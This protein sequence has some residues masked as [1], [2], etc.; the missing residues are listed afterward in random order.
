MK[1]IN[2]IL[3]WLEIAETTDKRQPWKVKH[4]LGDI[5]AIV[6]FAGMANAD[7]W[8]EIEIVAKAYEHVLRKYL[9]L[10]NGIPSHD[11]IQRVFAMIDPLYLQE[12]RDLWD[13]TISGSVGNVIRELLGL[14]LDG[15]TE[16]GN[17]TDNQKPNHIVSAVDDRGICVGEVKTEEKSNEITAIP[18]LLK[19]LDIK[20]HIITIDAM[21]CQTDI[22]KVIVNKKAEYVLAVKGNQ[23]ILYEDIRLYF[24]DSELLAECLYTRKLEKAHGN[25][26]LREYW[27]TEDISW[28]TQKKNWTGL[29]TIAMTKNTITKKD[30]SVTTEVRYF[31][32]SLPPKV[33]DVAWAIRKHWMVESYHWHLDVTFKEDANKTLEKR[34]AY[35]LNIIRKMAINTLKLLDVGKKVSLKGKRL[36]LCCDF[37]KYL[38]QL[39][40]M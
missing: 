5:I 18:Q 38:D 36:M 23:P 3:Q 15:K 30:G 35:N 17:G 24:E 11:T 12:F 2:D 4:S 1:T 8:V 39:M 29:K 9:K 21:G 37:E 33:E 31:I 27:Q 28:L 7:D 10:P 22:A 6:S 14:S 26:E 34:A 32:S 25:S 13:E 16:R 19:L 20:G 40:A